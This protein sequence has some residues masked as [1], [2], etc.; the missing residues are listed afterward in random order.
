MKI[1]RVRSQRIIRST[2][3]S[4]SA[5]LV[6]AKAKPSSTSTSSSA[7]VANENFASTT[8]FDD[9][10]TTTD[11]PEPETRAL[12]RLRDEVIPGDTVNPANPSD[13]EIFDCPLCEAK[14]I[15]K[16]EVYH[17]IKSSHPQKAPFK[18]RNCPLRF[19]HRVIAG[20]HERIC[21]QNFTCPYCERPMKKSYYEHHHRH[22][23]RAKKE[24]QC[25]QCGTQFQI[26][27]ELAQ[28]L[29][30]ACTAEPAIDHRYVEDSAVATVIYTTET[31]VVE[32]VDLVDDWS[33]NDE[34]NAADELD[35]LRPQ[36]YERPDEIQTEIEVF[37]YDCPLCDEKFIYQM[38]VYD[39]MRTSKCNPKK[40][41]G[42]LEWQQCGLC[43]RSFKLVSSLKH[44]LL[45]H[46]GEKQAKKRRI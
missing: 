24:M 23:C 37:E 20:K 26:K 5:S 36:Q 42:G 12:I 30:S 10:W 27:F 33:S 31:P 8:E 38:D 46:S 45:V 25:L 15:G 34:N 18:C 19:S 11:E 1:S 2:G 35:P 40:P 39:H 16:D 14:F 4:A 6:A 7:T 32:V 21:S 29:S 3:A 17:H 9:D 41:A 22:V 44:H 13:E 43:H 28:H